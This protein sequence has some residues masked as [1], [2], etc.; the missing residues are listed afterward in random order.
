MTNQK[1]GNGQLD[2]GCNMENM[3]HKLLLRVSELV[4]C[5]HA[6]LVLR[7]P[8]SGELRIAAQWGMEADGKT[9]AQL[10]AE[11]RGIIYQVLNKGRP[12]IIADTSRVLGYVS[13]IRSN[14]EE[15]AAA[16]HSRIAVPLFI[17]GEIAGVLNLESRAANSYSPADLRLLNPLMDVIAMAVKATHHHHRLSEEYYTLQAA[18]AALEQHSEEVEWQAAELSSANEQLAAQAQQLLLLQRV[19]ENIN[20]AF[21]QRKMLQV[22]ADALVQ[23]FGFERSAILLSQGDQL[24]AEVGAEQGKGESQPSLR[25]SIKDDAPNWAMFTVKR[26]AIWC[27]RESSTLGATLLQRLHLHSGILIPLVSRGKLLG[28]AVA[29]N[30]QASPPLAANDLRVFGILSDYLVTAMDNTRLFRETQQRAAEQEILYRTVN[31]IVNHRDLWQLLPVITQRAVKLLNAH[32]G[33]IYMHDRAHDRLEVVASYNMIPDLKGE[34]LEIGE[35]LAGRVAQNRRAMRVNDYS[36]WQGRAARFDEMQFGAVVGVPLLSK[37]SELIG[38]LDV[39]DK[40]GERTFDESDERLL[41]LF[42][43]QASTVMETAHL[44]TDLKVANERL[45][46]VSSLK[47]EFLANMS[48]ELRTPLNSIIGYSEV[49]LQGAY[50][51]LNDKQDTALNKVQRNARNLLQLIN[52]VLDISRIESGRFELNNQAFSPSELVEITLSLVETQAQ[53]KGVEVISEVDPLLP[54]QLIGD[55]QRLQQVLLNLMAN[56]VKFTD[57]GTIMVKV[58]PVSSELWAMI[59]VDSGIGLEES[60]YQTIFDEFRQVDSST[61]RQHGGT[62]LGLAITR[63]LVNMMGGTVGVWSD[64]LGTGSTFTVT[65]PLVE[66]QAQR[67]I[68]EEAVWREETKRG[69]QVEWETARIMGNT[70]KLPSGDLRLQ[71]SGESSGNRAEELLLSESTLIPVPDADADIPL[72]EQL[73]D[74]ASTSVEER[75]IAVITSLQTGELVRGPAAEAEARP[76]QVMTPLQTGTLKAT[77]IDNWRINAKTATPPAG[78]KPVIVVD[79]DDDAREIIS[80]MLRREGHVVICASNLAAAAAMINQATPSLTII[81]LNVTDGSGVRL[82]AAM[83]AVE[84]TSKVPIILVSANE[85]SIEERIQIQRNVDHVL[86]KSAVARG[87]LTDLVRVLNWQSE[88]EEAKA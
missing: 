17:D 84:R 2:D 37:Q 23:E 36:R 40:R 5:D 57:A 74:A 45:V 39:M 83:R 67:S 34:T 66:P 38:V 7:D 32:S 49:L 60:D 18:Y 35:G 75:P 87:E 43:G 80:T 19:I 44:Y 62:G 21:Q 64:G 47:I 13:L 10:L 71:E 61:T 9:L 22:V 1:S 85:P 53:Q 12:R 69:G 70:L 41:T 31:D 56:A 14:G 50:G 28:A 86:N 51:E 55:Q 54:R 65:L 27:N 82:A 48:H 63:R 88:A 78:V 20:S 81:D 16:Q 68:I 76:M 73:R 6:G 3:L 8:S 15:E 26:R 72:D 29:G 77:V 33:A 42:A 46:A 25:I 58:R 30:A 24:L 59:V 11:E 79:D 52:D 4:N